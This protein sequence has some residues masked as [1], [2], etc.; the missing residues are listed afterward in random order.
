MMYHYPIVQVMRWHVVGLGYE[1]WSH[2]E[3]ESRCY[4]ERMAQL[5]DQQKVRRVG[6]I[7]EKWCHGDD[8]PLDISFDRNV[9]QF[10]VIVENG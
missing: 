5:L 1:C 4:G 7:D 3:Q 2:V 9:A 10:L 8:E 6:I